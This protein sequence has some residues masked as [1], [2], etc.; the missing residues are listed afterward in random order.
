M[1][2]LL[3]IL[4]ILTATV[5]CATQKTD[6][7]DVFYYNFSLINP[8]T[9]TLSFED[10]DL[11]FTF[12]PGNDSIKITLVNKG[13]HRVIIDWENSTYTDKDDTSHRLVTKRIRYEDKDKPQTPTALTPGDR[14]VEWVMPADNI[15]RTLLGWKVRSMFPRLKN[16][17][18]VEI[19]DR[20]TFKVLLPID[21]DG[22]SRQYEFT[23]KVK[24]R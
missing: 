15:R 9:G 18:T 14:L 2:V 6:I 20:T 22:E 10:K 17:Y 4:A 1:K 7:A 3:A 23:F 8:P 11:R 21:I 24:T 16:A 19:W 12:E 5:G 13:S